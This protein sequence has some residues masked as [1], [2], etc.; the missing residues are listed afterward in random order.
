MPILNRNRGERQYAA[1]D[2]ARAAVSLQA[3][4][5]KI[6]AERRKQILRYQAAVQN[7]SDHHLESDLIGKHRT[8][9]RVFEQGLVSSALVIESH[10]QLYEITKTLNEQ[11]LA[12][13]DALWRIYLIDGQAFEKKL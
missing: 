5:D 2:E 10:R 9:E 7:L 3:A 12:A 4:E 1:L 8:I 6:S 11:E 13:L